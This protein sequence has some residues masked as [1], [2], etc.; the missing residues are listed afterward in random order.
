MTTWG[1]PSPVPLVV[2]FD[3]N[4]WELQSLDVDG[5]LDLAQSTSCRYVV[6]T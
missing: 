2:E 5:G 3:T 1:N 6:L 4:F